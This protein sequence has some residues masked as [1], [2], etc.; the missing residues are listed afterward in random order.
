MRNGRPDDKLE[1]I[2]KI[3]S[4]G[5]R[6][7]EEAKRN[8]FLKAGKTLANAGTSSKTYW[9][10]INTVLNKIKIPMIPALLANGLFV[11]NFAEKAQ[12]FNDYFLLQCTTINTGSELPQDTPVTTTL[13][14]DLI[15]SDEWILNFIRSL[16]PNKA[17]G[18]DEISARILKLSDA[19][20]V[21]PFWIIFANCLRSGLLPEV[22]GDPKKTSRARS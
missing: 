5:A 3:I 1:E 2:Q 15:I 7:I 6:L 18:W 16:N 12:I 20:L 10:L 14:S 21:L 13:I 9:T 19:A 11:K 17:H 4:E 8:Y 22:P